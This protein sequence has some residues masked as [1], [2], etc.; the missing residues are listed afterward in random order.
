[1][2]LRT[3]TLWFWVATIALLQTGGTFSFANERVPLS[4]VNQYLDFGFP[5]PQSPARGFCQSCFNPADPSSAP[6]PNDA[7]CPLSS[8]TYK[9]VCSTD[10]TDEPFLLDYV[11]CPPGVVPQNERDS[12]MSPNNPVLG[13]PTGD[14]IFIQCQPGIGD[15][16]GLPTAPIL[17]I[18][19]PLAY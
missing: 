14:K 16:C 15:P 4:R 11:S 3:A 12:C 17:F 13:I 19:P 9:E 7:P 1:M 2:K 8:N 10:S 18:L 5:T 6:G